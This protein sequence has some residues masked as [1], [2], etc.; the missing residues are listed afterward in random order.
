MMDMKPHSFDEF[1]QLL[2]K[3]SIVYGTFKFPFFWC[4]NCLLMSLAIIW[5]LFKTDL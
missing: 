4:V 5:L 1:P 3:L 2:M